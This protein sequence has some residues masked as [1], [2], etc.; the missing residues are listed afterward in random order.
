MERRQICGETTQRLLSPSSSWWAWGYRLRC[1]V[2]IDGPPIKNYYGSRPKGG[3]DQ[4]VGPYAEVA[5]IVVAPKETAGKPSS[6][7]ESGKTSTG[8]TPVTSG[9]VEAAKEFIVAAYSG[10]TDAAI[11]LVS[12]DVWVFP[13]P[14]YK[15]AYGRSAFRKHLSLLRSNKA[16]EIVSAKAARW[17][18]QRSIC[19]V[20]M[21][22]RYKGEK[23]L[24]SMTLWFKK[25][26]ERWLL[27]TPSLK[28][29]GYTQSDAQAAVRD[30]FS[31]L[32]RSSTLRFSNVKLLRAV[33]S[34]L[35]SNS[36]L[37]DLSYTQ[38]IVD[39]RSGRVE[40]RRVE[41]AAARVNREGR[42]WKYAG[43]FSDHQ[44]RRR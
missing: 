22:T 8:K 12:D 44:L 4:G 14:G 28:L 32:G 19:K 30:L 3:Q 13:M 25:T 43:M 21:V 17:F 15:L 36:L 9:P 16:V 24:G 34:T 26:G 7:G 40:T 31:R 1:A 41:R 35:R 42:T 37:L 5:I 27:F 11:R 6:K 23:P 33:P 10:K 20:E 38:E 18:Q 39:T 29:A 2:V